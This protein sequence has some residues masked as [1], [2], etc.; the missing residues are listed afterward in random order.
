M[1]GTSTATGRWRP[2]L[3]DTALWAALSAAGFYAY[4]DRA[5]PSL[6]L[7][8][9]LPLSVLTVAV[10]G[11]RRRPGAAVFAANALCAVGL[12]ATPPAAS[13]Y[14]LALAAL[15]Y[16]LGVRG[17]DTGR[18]LLLLGTC[19]AVDLAVC[20]VLAVD[21][22]YWFYV[23]A[24]VP[25]ALLPPWLAGRHR[26]ARLALV[27]G[28]WERARV[29][30]EQQRSVAERAGLRER[31]RIAADVH[32]SLGH[33]LSLIALR[34]GALELSPTLSGQDRA[35]LAGLRADVADAV[36]HLR[37]TLT[38][39]RADEE[40]PGTAPRGA[41][42][43]APGTAPAAESVDALV[44]RAREAGVAAEVHREGEPPL[45]S[46]LITRTVHRVVQE[47][48]TNAVKHAPGAAVRIHLT[49]RADRTTVRVTNSPP[50]EGASPAS[51]AAPPASGGG[52][53]L[54]ALRERVQLVGGTLRTGPY[55]DGGYEVCAV[56]PDAVGGRRPSDGPYAP[57]GPFP[58]HGPFA[59]H[60]PDPEPGPHQDP[61]PLHGL[62]DARR[63]TRRRFVVAFAVPAALGAVMLVSAALL[64]H[65][66]TACVLRPADFAGLRTGRTSTE[67][68]RVLP[69]RQFPYVPDR[70]ADDHPEPP[71]TVC[72]FYRSNG[73]LL[74][75]VDIYRLC[76]ADSRLVAKDVLP[77]TRRG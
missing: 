73:N 34:A 8:L 18:A 66:L 29:L 74:E 10:P 77:G 56:L 75:Q 33:Q 9:L 20:A 45:R 68:A 54:T 69:E 13:P 24:L 71:G 16:L 42:V 11:S 28:G 27:H 46:P 25:L 22:V 12:A 5:A 67:L 48:L 38:V 39:L 70:V 17:T 49:H 55:G 44:R 7:D 32:D 57:Q 35:D 41:F 40:A 19:V 65:Q 52:H 58:P 30:A 36:G 15:A 72:A 62:A 2:V 3:H 51:P 21:A 23:L 26:Q 59:P 64:A 4:T 6:A 53:G 50:P 43:D 47:S 61:G 14:L 63:R 1:V 31:T 76:Y 60:A 37:E